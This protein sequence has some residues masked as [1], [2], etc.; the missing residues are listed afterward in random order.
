MKACD[1]IVNERKKQLEDCKKELVKK[2]KEGVKQEKDI[3]KAVGKLSEESYF[4]EYVRV[5]RTEGVGD[6]EATEIVE[7]LLEQAHVPFRNLTNKIDTKRQGVTKPKG[8]GKGSEDGLT[9]KQRETIWVH[10]EHTHEIRRI[11]KELAARVRSLRYFTAVRDL[12]KQRGAPEVHCNSSRCKGRVVPLSE[13]AML[14]SCGHMG[15]L[16]CVTECAEREECIYA[17]N[18]EG[19]S[20]DEDMSDD[21]SKV[22]AAPKSKAACKAA[23]RVIN[24]VRGD[25]LGVDDEK[26]DPTAKHYGKKI[27]EVIHL[28]K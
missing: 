27:E 9:E 19:Q 6:K 7:E 3:E 25:T 5:T 28:I 2:L 4:Q 15:C 10:R 14:S 23:A 24:I 18:G 1:M 17:F 26:R 11:T 22:N 20:G 8:K 16:T 12:Q 21:E 13:V